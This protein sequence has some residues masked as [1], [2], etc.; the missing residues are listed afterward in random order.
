MECFCMILATMLLFSWKVQRQ[1]SLMSILS[2]TLVPSPSV[3]SEDDLKSVLSGITYRRAMLHHVGAPLSQSIAPVT[4]MWRPSHQQ[5]RENDGNDSAAD[6]SMEPQRIACCST[7][8][9]LWVWIHASAFV[10]GYDTLKIACQKE[11]GERGILINC[12]SL[13]GQLAKIEVMGSNA[14]QLLQKT[15]HPVTCVPDNYWQLKHCSSEADTCSQVKN[16]SILKDEESVSSLEVLSLTVKDPRALPQ[17]RTSDDPDLP[18]TSVVNNTPDID[19]H[20]S[21]PKV[22]EENKGLFPLSQSVPEENERFS[23]KKSLWDVCNGLDPPVEETVICLERHCL[24]MD[25]FCVDDP[26]ATILKTSENTQ[27]SRSC[28]VMLLKTYEQKGSLPRWSLVL[29][30][31]WA[32]VF[33]TSFVSKGAHP[34]GLRE[35]HWIACEVGLPCFPSDFPDCN[36]YSSLMA[37]EAAANDSKAERRPPAIRPFRT[38]MPPPWDCV[39]GFS[40]SRGIEIGITQTSSQKDVVHGNLPSNSNYNFDVAS[41]NHHGNSFDGIVARASCVLTHFLNETHGDRL[42]LFPQ[43][44]NSNADL[45]KFMKDESKLCQGQN[46]KAVIDCSNKLCFL[47]VLIHAFKEGAFEEEAVV[48]APRLSDISLWISSSESFDGKLQMPQ[49]AVRSY[50]KEQSSGKWELQ[51]PDD[52]ALME[53]HRWPIGFVTTGFVRG[54]KKPAAVAFCEASML[55]RL[56]KEQWND[57]PVKRRRKEIYVLV[58]NIKSSAYRLALASIVLEQQ[59]DDVEFL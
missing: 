4:Y 51:I 19:G 22:V 45:L 24:L 7:F 37:T 38:P 32:K 26:K 10:E 33:W 43:A 35:K 34:I 15:L 14:F 17:K 31:S 20:V 58:R 28:P 47:R 6:G 11:M 50:F 46:G 55:A 30:L 36:A 13:E 56:R 52:L 44:P 1:D 41:I 5:S 12:L 23:D 8:R 21:V 40:I 53:S 54:S 48:C 57:F 39:R 27:C 9:Q 3:Q 25:S 2:M 18:N 16:S 59:E 29:P 42:L 49:S